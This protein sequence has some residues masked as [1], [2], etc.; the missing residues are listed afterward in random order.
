V[1]LGL[2]QFPD[3]VG[4]GKANPYKSISVYSD[5]SETKALEDDIE[6]RRPANASPKTAGIQGGQEPSGMIHEILSSDVEFAK[7]MLDSSHSDAEI[8]GYLASRGIDPA[9]A[10]EL[11]DN[12]RHGRKPNTPMAFVPASTSQPATES[13]RAAGTDALAESESRRRHSHGRRRHRQ[14]H[15]PWWFILVAAIF[16]LALAYAFFEAGTEASKDSVNKVKHELPP[17]PGK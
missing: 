11:L 13:G 15:R 1:V 7:G 5:L 10:V 14:P 2:S 9:K 16:I 12:L 3:L 6:N 17:P 4:K 8:L